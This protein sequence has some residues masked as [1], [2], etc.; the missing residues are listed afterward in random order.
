MA[1]MTLTELKAAMDRHGRVMGLDLGSKT[2]GL[3][4]SDVMRT[5]AT[6]YDT[7]RR[8]KFTADAQALLAA[9]DAEDVRGL[10]IGLPISMDGTEG[11]RCQSTRQFAANLLEKRDLPIAFWDERLSTVAVERMLVDDVDMTRAR[12]G[13]VVD[14]LAAAYILQGAL[15]A[16]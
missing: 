5:I 4:L 13:Q 3:A 14:K 1:V 15:D 11:P 2:I 6:P 7:I 8:T 9:I 12:R 16:R 10:V